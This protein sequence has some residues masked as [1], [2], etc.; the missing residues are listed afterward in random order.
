MPERKEWYSPGEIYFTREQIMFLIENFA[1]KSSAGEWELV[2]NK[3]P[4]DPDKIDILIQTSLCKSPFETVACLLAEVELRI[5]K[6]K[7]DGKLLMSEIVGGIEIREDLSAEA[8]LALNYISG[9]KRKQSPYSK[10]KASR[11]FYYKNITKGIGKKKRNKDYANRN[12]LRQREG[13]P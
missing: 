6:T 2:C 9:W 1:E 3:W 12:V 10:W 8:K 13:Q 11:L 7:T 5:E 4:P